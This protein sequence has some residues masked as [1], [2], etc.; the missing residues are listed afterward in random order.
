L[1]FFLAIKFMFY[2]YFILSFVLTA[3]GFIQVI[4]FIFCYI[5][6]YSSSVLFVVC[7]SFNVKFVVC[8]LIF[9]LFQAPVYQPVDVTIELPVPPEFV[10]PLRDIAAQEGTRVTFDG[11]VRG[12]PEPTIRWYREGRPL[13]AGADFEISYRDGRVRL[14]IPEVFPEDGGRYVCS[15]E[16]KA[17]RSQSSA[18]LIVKG[19]LTTSHLHH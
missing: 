16:N 9:V 19:M 3:K 11:C 5:F 15:A 8:L 10:E 6:L 1:R 7:H 13:T 18:E 4:C 2:L 14:S 12:K 17:G